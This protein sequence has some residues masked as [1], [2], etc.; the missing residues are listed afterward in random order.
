M[1]QANA[2]ARQPKGCPTVT[3]DQTRAIGVWQ[4]VELALL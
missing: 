4:G 1:G 2:P 3:H